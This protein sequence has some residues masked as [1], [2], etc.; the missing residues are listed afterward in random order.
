M[1]LLNDFTIAVLAGGKSE[2]F[3]PNKLF[4]RIGGKTVIEHTISRLSGSGRPLILIANKEED[5]RF[6]GYPVYTDIY[7]GKGPI[8]GIHAAL[9]YA[10]TE[11]VWMIGGD[12]IYAEPGLADILL[13]K[14]PDTDCVIPVNRNGQYEPLYGLY[15]ESCLPVLEELIVNRK[16][17]SILELYPIVRTVRVGWEEI[18]EAGFR[19]SIFTNINSPEDLTGLSNSKNASP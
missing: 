3:P 14:A 4:A 17:Y 19:E 15:R 12:M 8:S 1:T 7:K 5:Y 2:R 18:R 10:G 16:K 9:G 13:P 11:W 6:L